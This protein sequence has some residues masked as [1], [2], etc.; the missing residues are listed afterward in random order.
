VGYKKIEQSITLKAGEKKSSPIYNDERWQLGEVVVLGSRS[1]IP[2]SNLNTAVPVD[3]FS[4]R[5]LIQTGQLGTIQ[6]LNFAAPSVNT[7]R[8]NWSE[9]VTLRGLSPDHLLIM[10]NG[11]RYH[12]LA[13]INLGYV[14]GY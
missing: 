13:E 6:S 10:I 12:G 1:S 9:P 8:Q 5:S 3:A 11:T 7:S 14:K 2:R 4:S